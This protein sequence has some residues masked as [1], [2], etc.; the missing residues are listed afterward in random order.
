MG[1]EMEKILI[2]GADGFFASRFIE[3]YRMKYNIIALGRKDLDITDEKKTIEVIE[4][5]NPDYVIHAAALSDTGA[6]ERN[7][8]LSYDI[9]VKGT[10][11]IAKGCKN[12]NSKLIY[13]S[14]DQVY[15]NNS[16]SGPYNEESILTPKTVYA[17]HKIEAEKRIL[18]LVGEAV[19]LRITWLFSLPE[20][21]KRIKSNIIW[22]VVKCAMENKTIEFPQSDYRGITYVYDLIEV[23]DRILKIPRGIYNAG[24]END[25]GAYDIAK[26]VF[27]ELNLADMIEELL[28]KNNN[29]H[30]DIRISNDKLKTYDVHFPSTEE[31]VK[32]C[33]KDF[34]FK[35]Q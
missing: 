12:S 22:N 27:N 14:S 21:N 33:I 10:I 15:S 20:R 24:S 26:I 28:V 17:L 7:P 31:A 30:R 1:K 23:F 34:S 19:I 2:T 13:F 32:K 3:Y 9:N 6:C 18:E 16:S 8:Q 5:N 11:N 29:M 4:R 35:M 25:L